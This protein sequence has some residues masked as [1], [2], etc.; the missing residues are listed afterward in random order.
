VNKLV[1]VASAIG[2]LSLSSNAVVNTLLKKA[3][4]QL[5][6]MIEHLQISGHIQLINIKMPANAGTF[7]TVLLKVSAL[8]L[9]NTDYFFE[10]MVPVEE[11]EAL[12][13]NFDAMG[14]ESMYAI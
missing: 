9:V 10:I 13:P 12:S 6:G 8:D 1:E 14:Y 3:L 11:T 4:A 5:L 7:Y 2:A